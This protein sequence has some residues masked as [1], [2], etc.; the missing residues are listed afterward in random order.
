MPEWIEQ[1]LLRIRRIRAT[2]DIEDELRVHLEMAAED[3]L[4]LGMTAIEARRKAAVKFGSAVAVAERIGEQEFMTFADALR[5][6]LLSAVRAIRKTPVFS[7]TAI[8]TLAFGIGANTA[9]FALL[10]GLFLRSLPVPNPTRLA[11][12][13]VLTG[14]HND[15]FQIGTPLRVTEQYAA[16]QRSFSAVS[17]WDHE[18]VSMTDREGTLRL[19]DAGFVSGNAFQVLQLNPVAGRL[20]STAD[21]QMAGSWP[22][23]LAYDFWRTRFASDPNITGKRVQV[24]GLPATII[25]VAPRG[26]EGVLPGME[27]KLY[28]PLRFISVVADRDLMDPKIFLWTIAIA[29]L[30]EGST[31]KS[32][33]AE[34]ESLRPTLFRQFVPPQFQGMPELRRARFHISS[35]RSGLYSYVNGEY[36]EPLLILQGLVLVVLVLC[37]VNVGGLMMARVY[38]RD[39]E[40]AIRSAIGAG[41]SR[42][43]R[44]YL[45]ESLLIALIG[46]ALGGAAAWFVAPSLLHFL[47]NP[48]Q[49][50]AVS[51]EPDSM[52]FW[53]TALAAV[54]T[55]LA[56]GTLP[57]LRAS[58]SDSGVLLQFR[59]AG[60]LHSH[61]GGRLFIPA[62]AGLSLVLVAV[63]MLLSRSLISICAQ[64]KGFEIDRVTIQTPPFHRL[65]AKGAAKLDIYQRMLDRIEQMP[66][67]RSAAVTWFTPMSG[68]Q[69]MGHFMAADGPADGANEAIAFNAIGPGYFRTMETRILEGR[70]FTRGER[71]LDVCILNSSAAAYLFPHKSAMRRYVETGTTQVLPVHHSCRV[72]GIVEDAKFASLREP[73]PRTIYYPISPQMSMETPNL[74]FLINAE[75]KR[76]AVDAYRRALGEFAPQMPLVLFATLRDQMN[77]SLGSERLITQ[78]CDSFAA[79]ALFLSAIGIYGL[80]CSR[81]VERTPEIGIRMAMGARRKK[82]LSLILSDATGLL[83]AGL[84]LGAIGF[85]VSVNFLDKMLFQVS[86]FDPFVLLGSAGLLVFVALAAAGIPA[87]RAA[88]IEPMRALRVD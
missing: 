36:S 79:L 44:Q 19:Y 76:D 14:N 83:V 57:A 21:D 71:S 20:I 84:F 1:L 31:L 24:C 49:S 50:E 63:A 17:F 26:F 60:R 34:A 82:V 67:I 64:H 88:S 4:A 51:V 38:T 41:R 28:L 59:V 61:K 10:Y 3:N 33:T 5:L 74:V 11:N 69:A 16:R 18:T 7:I 81:V 52:V 77:A 68:D 15:A 22:V 66:G 54:L 23:V 39:R 13:S 43:I 9:I 70:E 8:L 45:V 48:M 85:L 86:K 62:Q 72:V 27:M 40:F 25:G 35:A 29:R 55:T 12:I 58:R 87:L 80:L 32:A 30:R 47:R 78:L 2:P 75:R 73:A 65:R 53:M 46:A 56:F 37:C 42:L 6:D